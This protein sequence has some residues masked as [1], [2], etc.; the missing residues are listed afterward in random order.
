MLG[1]DCVASTI[2]LDVARVS[3]QGCGKYAQYTKFAG[4]SRHG[5]P[6]GYTRT[7]PA[8]SSDWMSAGG[9]DDL[10]TDLLYYERTRKG[11]TPAPRVSSWTLVLAFQSQHGKKFPWVED[12][13]T[14]V[15]LQI[16]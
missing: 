13:N 15:L 16:K 14:L 4:T 10:C 8:I 1:S 11:I 12:S 7:R 2:L 6:S 3:K 5:S 9:G